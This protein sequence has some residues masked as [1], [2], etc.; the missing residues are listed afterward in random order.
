MSFERIIFVVQ[1]ADYWNGIVSGRQPDFVNGLSFVKSGIYFRVTDLKIMEAMPTKSHAYTMLFENWQ[2]Q[3]LNKEQVLQEIQ[4]S[5]FSD[6]EKSHI[7]S[8]YKKRLLEVRTNN[9]F[10]L[11][12]IGAFIG[13]ISCISTVYGILPELR[14]EILYGLTSVAIVLILWGGYYVFE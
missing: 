11:L 5:H 3:G 13:F 6:D 7:L 12:G 8:L 10:I 2:R 14:N 1:Q 9:G 4:E